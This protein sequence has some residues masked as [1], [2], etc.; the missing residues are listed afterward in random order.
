MML[1]GPFDDILYEFTFN[2]LGY[3]WLVAKSI[4]RHTVIGEGPLQEKLQKVINAIL[5]SL[6]W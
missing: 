6:W 1:H 3:S 5:R 4:M 2:W